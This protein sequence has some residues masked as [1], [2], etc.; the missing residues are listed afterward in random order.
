M[1]Y[2]EF[3]Q[4][5]NAQE[6]LQKL[7]TNT[8]NTVIF[9]GGTDLMV[10]ARTR[11]WYGNSVIID[12]SSVNEW[13]NIRMEQGKIHIGPL[14]TIAQLL[15]SEVIYRNAEI[16]WKACQTFA[17][18]QIRNRATIGGNLANAC[19]AADT[20]PALCVL[21]AQIQTNNGNEARTIEVSDLLKSVP[22]CLNHEE[23]AV[24]TCFYG[25]PAGKKTILSPG[26]VITDIIVPVQSEK[27]ATYFEK[28]GRKQIGC[29]SKFTVASA[30][31]IE[32]GVVKDLKLS[33]GAAFS[34]IRLLKEYCENVIGKPYDANQMQILAEQLGE[35]IAAQQKKPNTGLLYKA[36]VCK[37]LLPEVFAEMKEEAERR[38]GA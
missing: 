34:D 26:E 32:H 7:K 3:F 14:V 28:I 37:R 12:I 17:V 36:E 31:F 22:A 20:I 24:S 19:L 21:D 10:K 13:K 11:D 18:P 35:K 25:I 29:M 9:A 27:Y 5:A 4:A 33:I 2:K 8:Q 6:V 23:M 38:C 15:D 16:L 30:L 1:K